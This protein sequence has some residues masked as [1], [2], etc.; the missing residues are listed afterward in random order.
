VGWFESRMPTPRIVTMAFALAG[1]VCLATAPWLGG[2]V[3]LLLS[4]TLGLT[5]SWQKVPADTIV[6]K[7]T[8]DRFRGRVFALYDLAFGV[9]RIVSA[10]VAVPLIP[11]LS[12][13]ATVA[14]FGVIYLLWAPVLPRWVRRAPRV[15]L[16]FYAGGRAD[17]TPRAVVIGGEEEPV[18]V[19]ASWL[20][21][22]DGRRLRRFRLRTAWG[23]RVEVVGPDDAG[24]WKV[25]R[26]SVGED[27]D[28][29]LGGRSGLN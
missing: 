26:S 10:A 13:E 4:F 16:R 22:R 25:V 7:A 1:V 19:E 20:E 27:A 6:Q 3:I 12:T 8:P 23:E 14:L 11:A 15:R 9:T 28:S 5:F 29:Q 2:V 17:E 18:T 21:E 24:R